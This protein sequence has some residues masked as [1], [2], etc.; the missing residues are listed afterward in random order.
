MSIALT[1]I[2]DSISKI[3]V[4]GLTIKDLDQIPQQI[5]SRDCPML[6]PDADNFVSF[7]MQPDTL[8][9]SCHT[10]DYGLHYI[11]VYAAV[12]AGRTTVLDNYSGMITKATAVIDAILALSAL[13][14][15]VD[16]Y[17]SFNTPFVL[18]WGNTSYHA[19]RITIDATEFVN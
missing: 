7:S 17:A 12:G 14:G 13:T 19:C 3:S 6:I 11:L 2:A 8:N 5:T 9:K 18:E 10:I 16:W 4:S 15:A 1:T